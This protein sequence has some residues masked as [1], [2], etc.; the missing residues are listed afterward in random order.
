MQA[1]EANFLSNASINF[2]NSAMDFHNS[3]MGFNNSSVNFNNLILDTN[4]FV[5]YGS[6]V[7]TLVMV[8]L[9]IPL[10]YSII[11]YEKYGTNDN[12]TIVNQFFSA[13][14]WNLIAWNLSVQLVTIFRYTTGPIN[15]HLCFLQYLSRRTITTI[16]LLLFDAIS[17]MRYLF[18]FHLKNIA[19]FKDDF[20]YQ[21]ACLWIVGFSVVLQFVNM[22][23]PGQKPLGYKI[24]TGQHSA[25]LKEIPGNKII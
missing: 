10:L 22:S 15:S 20:W 7:L 2:N 24:C 16:T 13:I 21:F 18:I 19:T 25:N 9:Q 17:L 12:Q 23:L 11:W 5:K 1:E 8:L 6:S 14:C 4:N 3:S